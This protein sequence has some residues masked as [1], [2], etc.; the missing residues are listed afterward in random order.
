VLYL[1]VMIHST[2][3]YNTYSSMLYMLHSDVHVNIKKVARR[4]GNEMSVMLLLLHS[5]EIDNTYI[6]Y[7]DL[8]SY[9]VAAGWT[10]EKFVET[11]RALIFSKLVNKE[12][13]FGKY[14]LTDLGRSTAR[15][16][17]IQL[18]EY[19]RRQTKILTQVFKKN[20]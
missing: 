15:D 18:R 19:K 17:E 1:L 5:L 7:N 6:L 4:R 10:V 3:H 8:K 20:K 11:Q 14:H 9:F 16:I 2:R 12:S 13:N